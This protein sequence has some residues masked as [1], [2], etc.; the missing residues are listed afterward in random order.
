MYTERWDCESGFA[1]PDLHHFGKRDQDPHQSQN[2]GVGKA[3]NG[4]ME[5]RAHSRWRPG[6]SKWSR[7]G[8]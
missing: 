8:V 2:S 1:D 3:Q 5:G 4:L 7:G 6:G